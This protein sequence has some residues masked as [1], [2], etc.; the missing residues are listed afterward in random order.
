MPLGEGVCFRSSNE[1]HKPD[2]GWSGS[3]Y[4]SV[5]AAPITFFTS[6][7]AFQEGSLRSSWLAEFR[8]DFDLQF[9]F[10]ERGDDHW[11]SY[12]DL[13]PKKIKRASLLVFYRFVAQNGEYL[14][15]LGEVSFLN[16]HNLH[17]IITPWGLEH[18][19]SHCCTDGL[20][21]CLVRMRRRL[22][23]IC[24]HKDYAYLPWCTKWMILLFPWWRSIN[25]SPTD[26]SIMAT[27][28]NHGELG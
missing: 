19:I 25:T 11:S 27:C 7:D 20:Y 18:D 21:R 1:I 17:I 6:K 14:G 28:Y 13:S 4:L 12:F 15:D 9:E 16:C 2:H 8:R 3:K 26:K 5:S 23:I 24:L 10:S 22:T